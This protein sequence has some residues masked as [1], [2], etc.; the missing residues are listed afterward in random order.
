[1]KEGKNEKN[2]EI[3]GSVVFLIYLCPQI[4]NTNT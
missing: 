4:N 1:M 3:F 2:G